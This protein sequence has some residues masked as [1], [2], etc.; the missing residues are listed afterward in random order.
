MPEFN[1]ISWGC[2]E[3]LH[4]PDISELM[5]AWQRGDYEGWIVGV[6]VLL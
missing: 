6:C 2:W 5:E 1:E 4:S 3:G